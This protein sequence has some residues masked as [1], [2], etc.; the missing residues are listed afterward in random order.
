MCSTAHLNEM[1]SGLAIIGLLG[2]ILDAKKSGII[3]AGK[4]VIDA[5]IDVGKL[6]PTT[7]TASATRSKQR[8]PRSN[9]LRNAFALRGLPRQQKRLDQLTLAANGHAR[10]T[11][12]PLTVGHVGL[13]VEPCRE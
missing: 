7:W 12:V 2:V 3:D 13:R 1:P 6:P 11:L 8:A 9:G 5:L 4:P 10:E